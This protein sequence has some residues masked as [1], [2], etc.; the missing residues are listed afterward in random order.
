MTETLV[1]APEEYFRVSLKGG[2]VAVRDTRTGYVSWSLDAVALEFGPIIT[3]ESD[4]IQID[5]KRRCVT[6][7]PHFQNEPFSFVISAEKMLA[8]VVTV[9]GGFPTEQTYF[10]FAEMD[11]LEIRV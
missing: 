2:M 1:E 7:L 10:I 8:L 9:D 4:D 3:G 6:C 5:S 11:P